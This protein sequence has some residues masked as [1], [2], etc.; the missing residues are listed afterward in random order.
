LNELPLVP[1]KPPV[2]D[3]KVR[4]I[5]REEMDKRF[6]LIPRALPLPMEILKSM[7]LPEKSRY[8]VGSAVLTKMMD[9]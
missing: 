7:I 2:V 4:V 6:L 1:Q 9:G 5:G 3:I 8:T